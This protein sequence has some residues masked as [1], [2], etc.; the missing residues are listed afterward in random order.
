MLLGQRGTEIPPS[1]ATLLIR[2]D[3][4]S[5]GCNPWGR[6]VLIMSLCHLGLGPK[7]G[8]SQ[9]AWGIGL[10]P[11]VVTS[12]CQPLAWRQRLLLLP[13]DTWCALSCSLPTGPQLSRQLHPGSPQW[14]LPVSRRDCAPGPASHAIQNIKWATWLHGLGCHWHA[15]S[16]APEVAVPQ[17]LWLTPAALAWHA[18]GHRVGITHDAMAAV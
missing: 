15:V 17:P 2:G 18:R 12:L 3:E 4:N 7:P 16:E 1:Q 9:A 14:Y 8:S 5:C 11:T 10:G 13:Q 6:N